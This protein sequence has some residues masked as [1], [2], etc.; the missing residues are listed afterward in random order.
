[1]RAFLLIPGLALSL[2]A[3]T[4]PEK[5]KTEA[6]AAPVQSPLLPTM[7]RP[8]PP[9]DEAIPGDQVIA[10]LGKR[11]IHEKDFL[12]WMKIAVGKRFEQV[13]KMPGGLARARQQYLDVQVLAAKAR[14]S[15]LD[16][17]ADFK[18]IL[19][20]QEDQALVSVLTSEDRDGGEGQRLKEKAEN[21]SEDQLKAY[22]EKNAQRYETAE[23]FTARH[24]LVGLKGAPRMGDKGL[25]EE[26]AKARIAKLREDLKAGKSFESLAKDFSDDP[27]S[28]ANGGLYKDTPYGSFVPEFQEA[29]RQQEVGKVGE[30]VKTVYG[31]HLILVEGRTPKLPA[32]FDKVKDR[33]KQ[34]W[35]SEQREF[36]RTA[37]LEEVRK[38]MDF[39]AG[40]EAVE[41]LSKAGKK[42]ANR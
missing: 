7:M 28:K 37:F 34:Q 1:M 20:V 5:P 13:A 40:P 16:E 39:V 31:Y 36:L 38:E 15:H 10:R 35:T 4:A 22:F 19:K 9:K 42:P 23:K 30:P 33:V 2:S 3:Q 11:I 27:G 26:A 41:T 14:K 17:S 12:D 32:E 24:I 21:P 25:T 8:A 29:V 6:P 18:K